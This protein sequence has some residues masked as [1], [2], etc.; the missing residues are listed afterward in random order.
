LV[1]RRL[2]GRTGLEVSGVCVGAGVLGNMPEVFG[3]HVP[4]ERA[5]ATVH[6]AL[7]GP[8]NFL[9]TSNNYGYGESERRIGRALGEAGGLPSGFVL[10]TKVDSDASGDFSGERV[11]RSLD[12][13]LERLGLD[14]LELVY[15]HDPE[16]VTFDETMAPDGAVNALVEAQRNGVIDHLGVAGGPIEL[17]RRYVRTGIFE[18]VLTHNRFTLVD[19]SAEALLDEANELGVA[20]VNAAVFGGGVLAKGPDVLRDYAYTRADEEVMRRIEEMAAT[21][22]RFGVPLAAA[23]LQFSLRDP[24]IASTVV[25]MSAP[26]R[27]G[28]TLALARAHVPDQLWERLRPLAAPKD[29]WLY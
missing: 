5:V 24:R 10:A 9:D 11:R 29:S 1:A 19:R 28:E 15:L 26:E 7:S 12:E 3:Y 21:C 6:S 2:L 27:V 25:G 4:L 14:R 23:A 20:V 13:S 17:M 18:V 22:L 8:F 16:R